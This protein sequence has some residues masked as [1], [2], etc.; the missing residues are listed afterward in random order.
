[1]PRWVSADRARLQDLAYLNR[2]LSKV[3]IIDTDA[4]HVRGQPE[5]AILLPKWTGDPKDNDLVALIP[6]LEYIHTMQ[7]GDVRKVLK[8]FEGKNIPTE[9]A[10][11]EAIAR[12]EFEKQLEAQ[13]VKKKQKS[14]SGLGFLGSALG[15]KPSSV[16]MMAMP[17]EPNAS[18]AFSQGKMIQDIARE[19]GQRNYEFL[20][21]EI[22]ENGE[23]WLKEEAAMMEKAN[24]EAMNSVMSGFSGWFVSPPKKD[25]EGS[26]GSSGATST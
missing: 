17:D 13:G 12:A 5:N 23:K 24:K 4:K 9:F 7:Y 6:F 16:N 14:A 2:D 21:R 18:E 15:L 25:G 22:R 3:M 19:R 20:E 26:V 1:M 8:S 10:R 11:R